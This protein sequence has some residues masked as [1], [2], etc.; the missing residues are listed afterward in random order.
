M[1]NDWLNH[2]V[3]P[4]YSQRGEEG[5]IA[6]ILE[7][8]EIAPPHWCVELG[9]WD[10]VTGS[11]CFRFIEQQQFHAVLIEGHPQRYRQLVERMRPYAD[12]VTP[13]GCYASFEGEQRLD[14]LLATTAIPEQ[15]T[16]LSLDVDG[17]DYHL[18]ES[19]QR[20]RPRCVVVE[21]NPSIPNEVA[22]VQPRDRRVNQGSSPASLVELARAKGYELVAATLNNLFFVTAADF[23]RFEI[24]DNALAQIRTDYS[25]V[26]YLFNGYDG[27]IFIRGYGK[28]DLYSLDY[29]EERMQLIPAALQQWESHSRWIRLL[30]RLHRSLKK[31]GLL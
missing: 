6:A 22:F 2:Q 7:R 29:K 12:R 4:G 11:N 25:R 30:Q 3:Q 8:L 19:L 20:Y 23:P 18:W 15:F 5:I 13:I 14:A 24:A 31:R 9:A 28:L 1:R 16:L 10:G 26:T 27:H 17:N 21:F